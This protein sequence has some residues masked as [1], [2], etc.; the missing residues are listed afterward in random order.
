MRCRLGE[1]MMTRFERNGGDGKFENISLDENCRPTSLT[2]R[3][4]NIYVDERVELLDVLEQGQG[5]GQGVD[6][7]QCPSDFNTKTRQQSEQQLPLSII[8]VSST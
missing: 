2:R 8:V 6:L 4:D 5:Q 1:Q 3:F 7:E